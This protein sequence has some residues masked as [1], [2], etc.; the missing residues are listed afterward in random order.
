MIDQTRAVIVVPDG[1]LLWVGELDFPEAY[2][3][4]M[5]RGAEGSAPRVS[6]S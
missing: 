4:E 1:D 6:F 5:S 2:D 3:E